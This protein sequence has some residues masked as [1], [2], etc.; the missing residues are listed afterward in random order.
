MYLIVAFNTVILIVYTASND[1]NLID[2]LD[3]ID[4]YLVYIYIA[5]IVIKVF[6]FG[7]REYWHDNWN[8]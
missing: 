4:N 6:G 3:N 8:K 7:I 1:Q 2:T 5:E